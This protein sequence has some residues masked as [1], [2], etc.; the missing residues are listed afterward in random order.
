MG[1]TPA[2]CT[3]SVTRKSFFLHLLAFS[4]SCFGIYCDRNVYNQLPKFKEYGGR[5]QY[6]TMIT[7]YVCLVCYGVSFLVDLLQ[8][9]TGFLEN[10]RITNSGYQ[11]HQ[12]FLISLRDDLI[13][14]WAFTL[15]TFVVIMYWGLAAIDLEGLHPA[16]DRKFVPL[17]GW[18]NQYLHTIPIFVIFV[19]ITNVNYG[20]GS[21]KKSLIY[22][23]A[24]G[25]SYLS[26]ITHLAKVKG[27]WAYGFMEK[28]NQVQFSVFIVV[29]HVIFFAVYLIGRKVSS[30]V[31]SQER[32]EQI[33]IEQERKGL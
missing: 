26:W 3:P 10:K 2:R 7:A 13:S 23:V 6:L 5:T 28:L 21:Y 1:L 14:F 24:L 4:W 33:I 25:S 32:K 19:L 12:S 22:T 20:Y 31:W 9:L 8:I 30:S 11:E 15:S 16:E 29:C 17:F 18:Y 27:Y